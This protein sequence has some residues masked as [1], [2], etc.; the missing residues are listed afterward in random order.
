[1][2]SCNTV[3]PEFQNTTNRNCNVLDIGLGRLLKEI[4]CLIK[5]SIEHELGSYRCRW[6]F[7]PGN[8]QLHFS[9]KRFVTG[10]K[11]IIHCTDS[12]IKEKLERVFMKHYAPN[13]CLSLKITWKQGCF[14]Y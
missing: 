7:Q 3:K 13:I 11:T 9:Y 1:M 14:K 10:E 6:S 2:L 5:M 12:Q 8:K 4:A